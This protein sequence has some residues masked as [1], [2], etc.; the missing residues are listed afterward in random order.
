MHRGQAYDLY[1]TRSSI[2]PTE[3]EYLSMIDASKFL[4]VVFLAS[5]LLGRC[6]HKHLHYPVSPP[7]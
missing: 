5:L 4:S 1:W 6:F 7:V 2:V 3:K